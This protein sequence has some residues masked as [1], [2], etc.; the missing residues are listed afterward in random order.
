[1]KGKSFIFKYKTKRGVSYSNS[2]E[3]ELGIDLESRY[4]EKILIRTN[5]PMKRS[6]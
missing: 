5:F 1:M 3:V 6:V 4:K 2:E